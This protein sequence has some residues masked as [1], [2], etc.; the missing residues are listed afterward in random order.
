M[1]QG[2]FGC[3]GRPDRPPAPATGGNVTA[4]LREANRTHNTCKAQYIVV[5][6]KANHNIL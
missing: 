2:L 3:S 1:E 5:V 4:E 6:C